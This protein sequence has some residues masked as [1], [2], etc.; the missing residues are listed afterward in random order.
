MDDFEYEVKPC[1]AYTSVTAFVPVNPLNR[2]SISYKKPIIAFVCFLLVITLS[3]LLLTLIFRI[4]NCSENKNY[5]YGIDIV[6]VVIVY[7]NI[8]LKRTV[9]WLV[10]FYQHFASDKTRLKCVFEPSCSEYM[11]LAINKYGIYKGVYKG[12]KR[13]FRC[14]PPGGIDYP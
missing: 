11:L 5:V 8:I 7:C 9:I 12:I 2:P 4:I 14:H 6:G 3:L 1:N 13:L 10:H